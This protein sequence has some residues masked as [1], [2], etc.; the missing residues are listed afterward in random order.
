MTAQGLKPRPTDV[1]CHKCGKKGHYASNCRKKMKAEDT[2][3][4][5]ASGT[6]PVPPKVEGWKK[7]A[8]TKDASHTQTVNSKQWFWCGKCARWTMS[9]LTTAHRGE[10]TKN[11]PQ[12]N[13]STASQEK[14]E[15]KSGFASGSSLS[16]AVLGF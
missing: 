4:D 14:I 1:I 3:S 13:M 16:Y 10:L 15:G 9:H 12:A 2:K 11:D 5:T 8:P 6:Q 7:K